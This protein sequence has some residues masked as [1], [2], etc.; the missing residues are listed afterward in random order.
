VTAESGKRRVQA[1]VHADRQAAA[2]PLTLV[3]AEREVL[4]VLRDKPPLRC[5]R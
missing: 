4:P 3:C 1:V 2:A 5:L